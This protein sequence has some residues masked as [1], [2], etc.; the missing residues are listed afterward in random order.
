MDKRGTKKLVSATKSEYEYVLSAAEKLGAY[1][2]EWIAVLDSQIVARGK[3][4]REVYESAKEI[5]S[6]RVPFIMK[7]PTEKVMI[8]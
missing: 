5:D 3:S 1:V 8:L 6:T 7:V 2:D 4:A